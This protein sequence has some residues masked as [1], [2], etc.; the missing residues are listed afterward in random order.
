[1]TSMT[2]QELRD[3]VASLAVRHAELDEVVKQ[4]DLQI[5]ETSQSLKETERILK[6]ENRETD[7]QLRELKRQLG[8][9]GEKFGGFTE[10]MALPSMRKLL[11]QRFHMDVI[12]VRA[13]ARKNGSSLELDVLA[14]SNSKVNEVYV[15][16]VKSHLRQEG[17]DQMKRILR[18][19]HSYFPG[20][21]GKKVYGIL[22]AVD[23]PDNLRAK[24]LQ[25]G[26]YLALIHDDEFSLQV[27]DDFQPRA[28]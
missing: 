2:D 24:V 3:L 22:A 15:V 4:T 10:G 23:I 7:R 28:F 14:Y 12:T 9:L 27:P 21:D 8:G 19:F 11:Q 6:E 16:E 5:R 18:D 20:H 13:L 26:I 1:M 25:E 17:L